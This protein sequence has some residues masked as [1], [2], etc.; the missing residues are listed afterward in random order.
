MKIGVLAIQGA[1]IEHVNCLKKLKVHAIQVKY[2]E[3]LNEIDGLIIPGGESTAISIIADWKK[4]IHE[5]IKAKPVWGTC[6]GIIL[7]ADNVIDNTEFNNKIW[8][9]LKCSVKRNFYGSL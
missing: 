5:F 1:F 6:A 4:E 8:G 3:Q 7:L 9:G 2:K